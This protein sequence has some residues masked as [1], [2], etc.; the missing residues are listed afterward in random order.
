MNIKVVFLGGID[1]IGKNMTLFEFDDEA[2]LVDA[3]FKFP[4]A[5]MLGVDKLIPDISYI[6][7][8][9]DKIK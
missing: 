2:I 4:D 3:G 1:E 6:L 7:K 9:K 5:E 8:I